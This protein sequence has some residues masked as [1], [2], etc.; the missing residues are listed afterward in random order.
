[1]KSEPNGWSVCACV[2]LCWMEAQVIVYVLL[3]GYCK[4]KA[5]YL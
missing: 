1:L 5:L 2:P 4:T 3:Q